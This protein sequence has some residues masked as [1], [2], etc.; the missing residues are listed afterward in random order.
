MSNNNPFYLQGTQT[1]GVLQNLQSPPLTSSIPPIGGG[2]QTYVPG[3]GLPLYNTGSTMGGGALQAGGVSG[4]QQATTPGAGAAANGALQGA[5]QAAQSMGMPANMAGQHPDTVKWWANKVSSLASGNDFFMPHQD[6]APLT[7]AGSDG[8]LSPDELRART[9]A[10]QGRI[11]GSGVSAGGGGGGGGGSG[12]G[13]PPATTPPVTPPVGGLP[14]AG[15]L[16][17]G[18]GNNPNFGQLGPPTPAIGFQPPGGGQPAAPNPNGGT[19]YPGGLNMDQNGAG[20]NGSGGPG[21]NGGGPLGNYFNTPGYQLLFGGNGRD[22]NSPESRFRQ[23]PGYQYAVGEALD[24]VQRHGASRGLLE[25]GSVMRDMTDRAYN[26]A[27]QGYNNWWDRQ[28]TVFNEHQN[29]LQGLAGADT[30]ANNAFALG[31][32]QGAGAMQT[33]SNLASLFGNQGTSGIGAYTGTG[34][35]QANSI[36]QAGA[37]QAQMNAA[38]RSTQLAA[39]TYQGL[40]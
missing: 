21:G 16:P 36:Q 6:D 39:A 9:N 27:D 2:P 5:L 3:A 34:A 22:G 10:L 33:G 40:F 25:S 30:G 35:A 7:V 8:Q 12:A 1:G 32:A 19:Y 20:G 26:M 24:Q 4:A 31:Q 23:D 28:H 38:N 15:G 29:R 17:N 11:L 18:G 14:P 37:T 13:S